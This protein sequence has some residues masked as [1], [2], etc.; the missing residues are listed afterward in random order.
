MIYIITGKNGHGKTAYMTKLARQFLADGET[1]YANY[2][3]YPEKMFSK[4]KFEKLFGKP[5]YDKNLNGQAVT[6]T[7]GDIMNP[8]DRK[9]CKILYWENFSDWEYF[10]NGRVLCTEGIKYFNA[11]KWEALPER[12]TAKFVEHRKDKIDIFFDIQHYTF[13]DKQLRMLAERF[14][15]MVLIFGSAKFEKSILPRISRAIDMD[16]PTLNRCENLGID[17]YD[18]PKNEA[19]K[20][21][22]KVMSKE[23]F[24]IRKKIFGWYDTAEK[25]LPPRPEALLHSTRSCPVCGFSKT[26]HA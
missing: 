5:T 16:L 15:N 12:M 4:K 21:N 11:R 23:F 24:W 18:V 17:P 25:I 22:I 20:Y 10:E 13:I 3:L 2:K 8:E 9:N 7:E 1:I 19:E 26:T 14:I 6:I